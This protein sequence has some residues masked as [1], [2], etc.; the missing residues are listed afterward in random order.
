L[1]APAPEIE[2]GE[3]MR[4]GVAQLQYRFETGASFNGR[5]LAQSAVTLEK[6]SITQPAP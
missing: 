5:L 1:A 3:T 6:N 4:R 2:L